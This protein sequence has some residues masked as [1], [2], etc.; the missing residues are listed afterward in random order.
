MT[1][2][3]QRENTKRRKASRAKVGLCTY[4]QDRDDWELEDEARF[5]DEA[6]PGRGGIVVVRCSRYGTTSSECDRRL[7]YVRHEDEGE[8]EL[9]PRERWVEL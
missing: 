6:D 3:K 4:C 2:N 7:H 9:G 8:A 5:Y 1:G